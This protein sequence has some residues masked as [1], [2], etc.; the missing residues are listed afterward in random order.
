MYNT[1]QQIEE[2]IHEK[3][4]RYLNHHVNGNVVIGWDHIIEGA[5]PGRNDRRRREACIFSGS[6]ETYQAQTREQHQGADHD[7]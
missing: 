1:L 2:A 4:D 3:E 7:G 5:A 6:S